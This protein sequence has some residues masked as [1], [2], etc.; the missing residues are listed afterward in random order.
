VTLDVRRVLEQQRRAEWRPFEFPLLR[1]RTAVVVGLGSIGRAVCSLL[2]ANGVR[3]LGVSRGGQPVPEAERT[4][5]VADLEQ[6]LPEADFLV[7]V[8]PLTAESRGLVD[9]Q[10][11]ARLPRHAWLINVGRG[12]LVVEQDLQAALDT[13]DLAG[14]VLDVFDQEPLPADHPYWKLDNVIVT[15]HMSG[16]DDNALVANQF[17]EN[18]RRLTSGQPLLGL[19]DRSR[20]Y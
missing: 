17:L 19:V 15:P 5:A 3:V 14:A 2:R 13:G 10:K 16:P 6:V 11:L 20:G 4:L 8:L 18:Y 9:R 12:P 7:L 1:D